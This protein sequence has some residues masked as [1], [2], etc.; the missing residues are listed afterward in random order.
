M[1]SPRSMRRAVERRRGILVPVR[2]FRAILG[3]AVGT[4]FVGGFFGHIGGQPRLSH[5]GA[6][7]P[8]PV[9]LRTGIRAPMNGSWQLAPGSRVF[10]GGWFNSVAD[11]NVATI[12]ALG[13]RDGVATAWD[14]QT[15][16]RIL[17]AAASGARLYAGWR[18]SSHRGQAGTT[19]AALDAST[20]AA[21]TWIPKPN[22]YVYELEAQRVPRYAGRTL[23]F[24]W[25]PAARAM[26]RHSKTGSGIATA[27]GIRTRTRRSSPWR[28]AVPRCMRVGGSRTSASN[29]EA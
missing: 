12:A 8:L 9:R 20:G 10:A 29:H 22:S 28:S 27:L 2:R 11:L 18:L 3:P 24:H 15:R 25:R 14:P 23:H 21:T 1:G 16:R 7:T 6:R 19:L 5:R 13:C 17:C 4:V 26:S